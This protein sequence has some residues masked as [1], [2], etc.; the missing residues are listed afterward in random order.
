MWWPFTN[1]S[2]QNMKFVSP[3]RP[4]IAS[5]LSTGLLIGALSSCASSS[6]VKDEG[7]YTTTG[8]A[9]TEAKGKKASVGGSVGVYTGTVQ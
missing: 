5:V 3:F 6:K 1:L 8:K 9:A 4:V 7:T 2:L